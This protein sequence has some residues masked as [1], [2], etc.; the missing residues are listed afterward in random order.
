MHV[1]ETQ[2]REHH[3][4]KIL[5]NSDTRNDQELAGVGTGLNVPGGGCMIC[6]Y[7]EVRE[8]SWPLLVVHQPGHAWG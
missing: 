6:E 3:L 2:P 4:V 5:L 1:R 7:P 8:C